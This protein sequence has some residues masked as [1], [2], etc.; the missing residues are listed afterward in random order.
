MP[1]GTNVTTVSGPGHFRISRMAYAMIIRLLADNVKMARIQR[2]VAQT[3]PDDEVPYIMVQRIKRNRQHEVKELRK[4]LNSELDDLWITSKR[5]R[6]VG[7]QQIYEDCNR[8]VPNRVILVEKK[9]SDD[10]GGPSGVISYT[11]NVDGMLKALKQARDE[12]G[13][14]AEE[15]QASALETLVQMAERERGLEKTIDVESTPDFESVPELRDAQM[16]EIEGEVRTKGA[17]ESK[18]FLDGGDGDANAH[19]EALTVTAGGHTS[20]DNSSDDSDESP[21]T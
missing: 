2:A 1:G 17:D 21:K 14:S 20:D 5:E 13:E 6:L 11:K 4:R 10:D 18:G 19:A 12:L 7:L 15:K 9:K 8:W 3:H 16:L